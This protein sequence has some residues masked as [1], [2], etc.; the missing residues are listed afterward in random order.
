VL[1]TAPGGVC[2]HGGLYLY[3]GARQKNYLRLCKYCSEVLRIAGLDPHVLVFSTP[4]N[5]PTEIPLG[6]KI[7]FKNLK[8]NGHKNHPQ[9]RY[10]LF[11]KKKKKGTS[12]SFC[13][14]PQTP[15]KSQ[16]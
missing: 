15:K 1:D 7:F 5:A 14:G 10:P 8:N 6:F 3:A 2:L 9:N 4:E 16:G 12:T 13:A 11:L